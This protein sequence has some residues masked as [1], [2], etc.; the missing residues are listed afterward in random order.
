M[1]TTTLSPTPV[2]ID[3]PIFGIEHMAALFR[4]SLYTARE[5]TC[6]DDF[7]A[8]YKLGARLLWD[9]ADVLDWFQRLARLTTAERWRRPQPLDTLPASSYRRRGLRAGRAAS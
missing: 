6:R 8:A 2:S 3:D 5:Y 9:R 4:V 7:P 1:T